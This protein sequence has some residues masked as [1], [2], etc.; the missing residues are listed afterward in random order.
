[1]YSNFKE[2]ISILGVFCSLYNGEK[3]IKGYL[4]NVKEQTIFDNVRFYILDCASEDQGGKIALE[5]AE[6]Y[7]NVSYKRLEEDCGL[8]AAWNICC[9][10]ASEKY[11]GNW[12]VDDRRTPWSLEVMLNDISADNSL[13]LVY[14]KTAITTKAN[15]NWNTASLSNIYPCLPHSLENLLRNN[16][17][18]CMPIWKRDLHERFGGFN[19]EYMTA[20]DTD[21]WLRACKGGAKMKMI[22]DIVGL[23]YEN[24]EGRS[25]KPETLDKMIKEVQYVR[26]LYA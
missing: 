3:F 14:G 11:I 16:S 10:W 8:Y 17:P 2:G 9:S 20:S 4:E 25:T 18:H 22:N 12:N 1:M 13:D 23:Y 26:S 21:M 6:E 24:P 7:D 19:E 15:D 5:F